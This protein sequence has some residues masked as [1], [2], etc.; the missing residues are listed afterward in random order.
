MSPGLAALMPA[1]MVGWSAG[2]LM[3]V[4]AWAGVKLSPKIKRSKEQKS[5]EGCMIAA[6]LFACWGP[7]RY[8]A[9]DGKLDAGLG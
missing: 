7:G 5:L 3:T 6:G 9:E 4:K 1:W 2:T 8:L